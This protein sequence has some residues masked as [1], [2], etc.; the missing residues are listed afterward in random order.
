MGFFCVVLFALKKY[1][2]RGG[3]QEICA[4]NMFY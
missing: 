3:G 2:I 1:E 4:S